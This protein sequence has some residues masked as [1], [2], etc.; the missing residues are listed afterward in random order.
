MTLPPLEQQ[1]R[2]GKLNER[3]RHL[4]VFTSETNLFDGP[5]LSEYLFKED[6]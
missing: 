1:Q 4:K 6:I 3:R 5:I 2:I